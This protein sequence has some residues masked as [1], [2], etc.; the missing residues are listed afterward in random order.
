MMPKF[1]PH[2]TL[3]QT[4]SWILQLSYGEPWHLNA[5]RGAQIAQRVTSQLETSESNQ[6]KLQVTSRAKHL[7]NILLY[8]HRPMLSTRSRSRK[9]GDCLHPVHPV[10]NSLMYT[11][12]CLIGYHHSTTS[13]HEE[14]RRLL[15]S[16]VAGCRMLDGYWYH[17]REDLAQATSK[18]PSVS[19]RILR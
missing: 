15:A 4:Q 13:F 18:Q 11:M 5:P 2:D 3:T 17:F 1:H 6:C 16:D 7:A 10:G 14:P 12:H 8:V 9:V 19:T